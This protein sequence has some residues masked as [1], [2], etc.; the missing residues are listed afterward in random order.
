MT[1]NK[2]NVWRDQVHRCKPSNSR[3]YNIVYPGTV[4]P[5]DVVIPPHIPTPPYYPSG[6]VPPPPLHIPLLT[7][8]QIQGVTR[9]SQLA[10][11]VLTQAGQAIK[12]GITTEDMDVMVHDLCISA[13]A[14]PSPLHYRNFPKSVCT[15]VNNVACHGIP[16]NY[17]LTD[18][19]IINVDVTV[20]IGGYHGDC[21]ATFPVGDIDIAGEQLISVARACRDEAISICK[22]GLHI[23]QIGEVISALAA[24]AGLCVVPHSCGHGIAEHFH[25]PPQILHHRNTDACVLESGMVFTVEPVVGEGGSDI[26][27][28][29]DN[30]TCVSRDNSRSAQFEHTILITDTSHRVLTHNTL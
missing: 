19:D 22:P 1:Q 16:D 28:L 20:Y 14:Y 6:E 13:G 9:A 23:N 4:T 7:P 10:S 3:A 24:S 18:G 11:H 8:E 15:S 30:W 12:A 5:R 21:S 27:L 17:I 2:Q 26:Y 25:G 29:E